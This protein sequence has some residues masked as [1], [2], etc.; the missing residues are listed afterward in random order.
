MKT[1][2]LPT[3]ITRFLLA[4]M[5]CLPV[6]SNRMLAQVPESY[7]VLNEDTGTLTFRHDAKKPAGAY[8]LNEGEEIPGWFVRESPLTRII[9]KK[10]SSMRPLL[11]HARQVATDGSRD[12]MN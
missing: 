11:K 8:K 2:L 7:A 5:L 3:A 1:K 12:V 6:L 4:I 9:S 10:W